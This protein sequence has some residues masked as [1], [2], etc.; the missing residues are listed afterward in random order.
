MIAF[1]SAACPNCKSRK[2]I[3]WAREHGEYHVF[4]G[5]DECLRFGVHG[6]QVVATVPA[7]RGRTLA[8]A[9]NHWNEQVEE[10][11]A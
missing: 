11:A 10:V 4:C 6:G 5:R 8:Q 9:V 3:T 2:L 7:G 1:G